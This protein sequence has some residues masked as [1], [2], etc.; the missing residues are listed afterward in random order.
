MGGS[1]AGICGATVRSAREGGDARGL[2]AGFEFVVDVVV[3]VEVAARTGAVV[4]A[5][6]RHDIRYAIGDALELDENIKRE[7]PLQAE[8]E[9]IIG[10]DAGFGRDR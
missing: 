10:V 6:R 4:E 3:E 9:A 1:N 7:T 5:R 8:F 2:Y